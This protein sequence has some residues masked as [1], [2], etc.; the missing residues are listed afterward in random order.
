MSFERPITIEEA[1]DKIQKKKYYLPAI[2][3]EFVWKVE[4]I[5]KLFDSL[6]RSYPIGTFLLWLVEKE[7]SR[8]FQF[9]GFIRNYHE[10]EASHNPKADVSGE[11]D[12]IAI[13]DGQ[14]RLTALYLGLKGTY[15]YKL[16]GKRWD[17]PDAF[18]ARMLYLNLLNT[19]QDSSCDY[20]FRFL[21]EEES[22]FK[23]PVT[24]WFKVGDILGFDK[25]V[26]VARYP[27]RNNIGGS[28]SKKTEFAVSAL[29]KLYTVIKKDPVIHYFLEKDEKLEKVLNIFIRVNSGGTPLSYSDLLLSIATAQWEQKDAREEVTGFVDDA[30][31]IGSGFDIDKDFV[32][33]TCLV[34]SD[35][36]DI[37]FKVDNFNKKN[38]L[39]I[40]QEW[41][42]I[43]NAIRC[44]VTFASSYGFNRDTL[45]SYIALIPIAYYIYK[46]KLSYEFISTSK[47][48][49]ERERVYKW[50]IFTL[51]KRTFSGQP[52][53]VLR[54]VRQVIAENVKTFPLNQLIEKLKGTPKSIIF[55]DDDI[56][57][58]FNNKYG[59]QHTFATLALLYPTLDFKNK[60]HQDHIFPRSSFTMQNLVKNSFDRY[61]S[62]FYLQNFDYIA[63]LQLM[64]GIPNQEK[65]SMN[66][67]TWFLKNFPKDDSTRKEYMTK[68]YIPNTDLSFGNFEEFINQRKKL[69][70][71]KFLTIL[72]M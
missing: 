56:E 37:A 10:D 9:Y 40:E 30:N 61:K 41:D 38:M 49:E 54:P 15:A 66:F 33:K 47:F 52:D 58:L 51:L 68:H 12:L 26:D 39:K 6:M 43:S 32:L 2:Q 24:Y 60:F 50:L 45:P 21:T 14:Q 29:F 46:N 3:R 65:S 5:E 67:K 72:K 16:K 31:R 57:N 63:N 13:L 27:I 53:N 8:N 69:M 28:D 20:E 34:L 7:N 18:P 44:A 1:I 48:R 70:K 62:E 64:E 71:D 4:Q 55:D 17:N 36:P 22:T 35:F 19:S 11:D 42:R 59:G 23:D 25:E